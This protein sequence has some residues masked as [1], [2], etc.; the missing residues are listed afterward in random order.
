MGTQNQ[1]HNVGQIID[2]KKLWLM[3][4]GVDRIQ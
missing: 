4:K 2:G 3:N 1:M